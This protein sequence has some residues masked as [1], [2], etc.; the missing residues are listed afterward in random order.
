PVLRKRGKLL[1]HDR[2]DNVV[3]VESRIRLLH[4]RDLHCS[5]VESTF[6]PCDGG[7]GPEREQ[8]VS[9][10]L[11]ISGQVCS[12]IS[13]WKDR[14]QRIRAVYHHSAALFVEPDRPSL[15]NEEKFASFGKRDQVISRQRQKVPPRHPARNKG[16]IVVDFPF[17]IGNKQNR[18]VFG[19]PGF[20]LFS[21]RDFSHSSSLIVVIERFDLRLPA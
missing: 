20:A 4:P 12:R 3:I 1:F 7:I 21:C 16:W 15:G 2:P 10:K 14:R 13:R 9:P 11:F 19:G 8:R 18:I 5:C 17:L 6:V